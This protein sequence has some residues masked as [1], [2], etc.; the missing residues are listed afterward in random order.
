[1]N[2]KVTAFIDDNR[3]LENGDTVIVA[4]SGGAD[5]VTLLHILNS[6]KE[7]YNLTLR[8]AHLNHGIREEEADRDEDFVRK[9]CE[10]MGV[11]LDV[12][13]EDIPAIAK[14]CGKSEELCGREAR[15]AFFDALSEQYGAKIATAHNRDDHAETV[16]WNLVRGAGLSGLC[17]IPVRRG[18]I[19]RPLLGCSRAQIE[20]YCAEHQLAYVTDSTNLTAAYTRNRIRL[21]VMPILRQLNENAE[22]NIVRTAQIARQVDEYFNDISEK[23]LKSCRIDGGYDCEKL[24]ELPEAVRGYAI[25]RIADDA[26]APMDHR[27]VVLVTQAMRDGGAVELGGGYT[28]VCA[29]RILRIVADHSKKKAIESVLLRD[30]PGAVRVEIKGGEVFRNGKPIPRQKINKLFVNNLIPCAII[31]DETI[32]RVRR[33]GDTFRDSRRGVTK[34]LK[35]LFNER[36]IPRE[37]RDSV[38]VIANGSNVIW[39]EGVGC[40]ERMELSRDG[41]AYYIEMTMNEDIETEGVHHA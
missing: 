29:Q 19:I 9:L 32:V 23:E 4:L 5:S 37:D 38:P 12:R 2:K 40:C 18:E 25:K 8:A 35:K 20:A 1:M 3:L 24:L 31:T 39:I 6:V 21:E 41:E 33:E 13:R 17:G 27:H 22:G 7:L 15:Y 26:H 36:K 34:S 11:P 10:S 28:A 14:E 30:F 16:L